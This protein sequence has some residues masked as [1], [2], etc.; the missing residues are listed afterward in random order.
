MPLPR[1]ALS[2]A[3][4]DRQPKWL[5]L[6]H[7]ALQIHAGFDRLKAAV[8]NALS[9]PRTDA[10]SVQYRPPKARILA[11]FRTSIPSP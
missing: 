11:T 3:T 5:I 1:L 2:V 9:H 8:C 6:L 10:V 7:L 4:G